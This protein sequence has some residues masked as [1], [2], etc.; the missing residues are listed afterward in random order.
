MKQAINPNKIGSDLQSLR[1]VLDTISNE[2][3]NATERNEFNSYVQ[4]LGTVSI[5]A[6]LKFEKKT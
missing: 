1:T 2:I 3:E 5:T 4:Q 6:C